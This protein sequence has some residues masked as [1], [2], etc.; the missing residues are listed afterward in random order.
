MTEKTKRMTEASASVCLI[1]ATA[2]KITV[3]K[4]L[5][6]SQLVYVLNT[7]PKSPQFI[8]EINELFD[9]FL[10]NGRGGKIKRNSMINDYPEGGLRM[11]MDQIVNGKC[12]SRL[13]SNFTV[14]F[15][16]SNVI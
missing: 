6:A 2:L 14:E 15:Y 9:D 10:W 1:L 12:C 4:S 8:K 13:N 5:I 7:L 11:Y 3:Q 16:F